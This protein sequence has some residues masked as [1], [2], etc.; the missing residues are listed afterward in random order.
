MA[1]DSD[2]KSILTLVF[3]IAIVDEPSRC[4]LAQHRIYWHWLTPF[5][6]YHLNLQ[7]IPRSQAPTTSLYVSLMKKLSTLHKDNSR[8]FGLETVVDRFDVPL[9]KAISCYAAARIVPD[10][11]KYR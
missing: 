8:Y 9:T 1:D 2:L 5:Y 7:S 3:V 10:Y 11:E 6:Q 4:I